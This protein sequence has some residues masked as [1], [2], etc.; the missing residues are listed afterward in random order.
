MSRMVVNHETWFK[1]ATYCLMHF[2]VAI[3][4]AY[5]ISRDWQVA[6]SIGIAEPLCRQY[7]SIFM[8]GDGSY[9]GYD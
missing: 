4:V 2:T 7:F 6:L 1:T 3:L 8:S 5:L 9:C